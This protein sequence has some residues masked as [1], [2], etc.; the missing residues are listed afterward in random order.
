MPKVRIKKLH[1]NAVI[2][3]YAKM[4]DA[5]ADLYSIEDVTIQKHGVALVDTGI[6][7]E[8]P[9]GY[10]AQIRPR[11]GLALKEGLTV[12]NSPGTIDEGYR[13][14]ICVILFFAASKNGEEQKLI[15]AGTRVAQMVIKPVEQAEFEEIEELSETD[16]GADGF[17][18]T[19]R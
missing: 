10:E 13:G 6:A 3:S 16:R 15:P 5:G 17:G 14:K 8:L 18:S 9:A 12:L 2:P 1:E 19:G 4:G 7:I 11:S